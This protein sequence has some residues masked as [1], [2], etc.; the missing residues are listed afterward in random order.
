MG[1]S[2]HNTL[3]TEVGL[4]RIRG[5][6]RRLLEWEPA[7]ETISNKHSRMG[8][9]R[10]NQKSSSVRQHRI[11][12]WLRAVRFL[13]HWYFSEQ[14]GARSDPEHKIPRH[15]SQ[16]R[17]QQADADGEISALSAL[18]EGCAGEMR[19]LIARFLICLLRPRCARKI[20]GSRAVKP[21][22]FTWFDN[23]LTS[24]IPLHLKKIRG[25]KKESCWSK[26]CPQMLPRS[27]M[28]FCDLAPTF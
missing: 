4:K 5:Q 16:Q 19:R 22:S 18:G 7:K 13:L 14:P 2:D 9:F 25:R 24:H 1:I 27:R 15:S 11:R 26:L 12:R 10:N 20:A 28:L 3:F 8:R 17:H 6:G 23:K 21:S